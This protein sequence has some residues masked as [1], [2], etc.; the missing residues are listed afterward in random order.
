MSL[1]E[2]GKK[3]V[4]TKTIRKIE[5]DAKRYSINITRREVIELAAPYYWD[6]KKRAKEP[7]FI[8]VFTIKHAM[9]T[10]RARNEKPRPEAVLRQ[11]VPA[12]LTSASV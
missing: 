12:T 5:E 7:D 11:G 2:T 8:P 4:L 1:V 9:D 3:I 6:M 10:L